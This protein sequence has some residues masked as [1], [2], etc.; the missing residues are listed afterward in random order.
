MQLGFVGLGA[1]VETA[2]LP[3]LRN[4]Y[5]RPVRCFG[6]DVLPAMHPE[7]VMRCASLAELLATPLDT[8]FITTASLHHLEVLEQ[9]IASPIFRIV[10]EKPIVATLPQID[11]LNA[12]LA[13]PGA[14][15][16]V[17]ALDHWMARIETVKRSLVDHFSDVV[18]IEGFLQ[19]PS[20]YNAVGE[21]I[22]LNF[23]TGE[24]DTRT[25]RHPDGVILDIG[26]HVLA[27]LRETMCFLGGHDE[28]TLQVVAAKD[29][30]GRAIAKGD[31][32]TAEGEAH[33][34]G[35]ICGV[36][37]DIWLNKYAGP[38]G[39]Q[40]GLRLHLRDGRTI[41]HD[42]RGAEDVLEVIEGD[43]IQRWSL[44]G[45]IYEH[46]LAGHILG[47]KSLFERDP[48]E[49]SRTTRRRIEEVALLL[50]LQQ[51]LRGPH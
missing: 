18:R 23:S 9:A 19:E 49:V 25:L 43:D 22:A 45:T 44:P 46:C 36:P 17:L 14:V 31:L 27:M 1:V 33:L 51:Q 28:M 12:L 50:T 3:A 37:V 16:R 5:G 7:G 38:A 10:I 40:K 20:G 26:T 6:F 13:T 29:R 2:Y 35:S 39:G 41:S 21:P 32:T 24:P 34:Q 15:S 42:R 47:D 48:Q 8:L 4:L 30:L 11:K